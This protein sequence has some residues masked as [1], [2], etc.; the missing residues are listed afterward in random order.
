MGAR[1]TSLAPLPGPRAG[2]T[3]DPDPPT[4]VRVLR[5]RVRTG[6]IPLDIRVNAREVVRWLKGP[7]GL[8]QTPVSRSRRDE[9]S[10]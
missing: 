9:A 4:W 10:P 6:D 3:E 2:S 5:R 8:G 1:L 7:L